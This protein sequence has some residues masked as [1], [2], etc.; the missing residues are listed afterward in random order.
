MTSWFVTLMILPSPRKL[1]GRRYQAH[2][3]A[4]CRLLSYYILSPRPT[5]FLFPHPSSC[6]PSYICS[7]SC[8][9]VYSFVSVLYLFVVIVV[10][11]AVYHFH[12]QH[13]FCRLAFVSACF[14]LSLFCFVCTIEA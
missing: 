10:V 5:S 6:Y 13:L 11:W 7:S 3:G 1:V 12:F 9:L 4:F 14:F 8:C 2:A